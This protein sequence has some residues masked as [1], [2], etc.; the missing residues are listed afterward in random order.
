MPKTDGKCVD[1]T[2][3][4]EEPL[5]GA[6]PA[7]DWMKEIAARAAKRPSTIMILGETGSGKEMLARYIH[8]RSPRADKPFVPVD[9]SGFS[10]TLFE[11]QLFGHVRGAFTGAVRDTLGFVRAA[12]TGTLFL[13][14]IG[15]LSPALQAKM[16]RVLQDRRVVPVGDSR[17]YP[18][19]IRVISATHRDLDAMVAAGQFRQ[20]LLFRLQVIAINVPSLRERGADIRALA[21]DFLTRQAQ[22][23]AETFKPLSPSALAALESYSWPGNVRELFNALEQASVLADG[24]EITFENLP[25][26]IRAPIRRPSAS[27]M[28]LDEMIR[29]QITEALTRSRYRR[30]SAASLLGIERRRLN[31]FIKKFRIPFSSP[32]SAAWLRPNKTL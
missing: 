26:P 27:D 19:N 7:M 6:S 16:L 15:E 10:E 29:R 25:A 17:S 24:N 23:N 20:D 3:M 9:C 31:R 11:S 4:A 1:E 32:E 12:D 8:H 21:E 14:E 5:I 22:I 28:N 13:D 30:A 2:A 18:V